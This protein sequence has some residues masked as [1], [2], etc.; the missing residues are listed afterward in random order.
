MANEVTGKQ[1]IQ[2]AQA[3]YDAI[4]TS[5]FD[6][7]SFMALG[8]C[9][10]NSTP[11][12]QLGTSVRTPLIDIGFKLLGADNGRNVIAAQVEGGPAPARTVI[13]VEAD[14]VPAGDG[15]AES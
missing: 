7:L 13:D 5:G 4:G 12:E 11:W 14:P 1:A 9:V 8:S 6:T 3:L 10:K 15:P 2:I